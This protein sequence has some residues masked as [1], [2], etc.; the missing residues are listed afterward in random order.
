V[1]RP[2]VPV[3]DPVLAAVGAAC[4]GHGADL[5]PHP[6][7]L[8]RLVAPRTGALLRLHSG[9]LQSFAPRRQRTRRFRSR[10][11]SSSTFSTSSC[12]SCKSSAAGP[13][14]PAGRKLTA[15][16]SDRRHHRPRAGAAATMTRWSSPDAR[17]S[18]VEGCRR[19]CSAAR[20]AEGSAG[21]V[22]RRGA[23]CA[24]D[25]RAHEDAE[26]NRWD[27]GESRREVL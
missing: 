20:S 7:P 14:R 2:V 18:R 10:R 19:A 17:P 1:P 16:M 5:H 8:H 6:R 26:R 3:P 22:S 9:R 4:G 21:V 12:S 13:D 23:G 24:H 27:G 25:H 11:A 15:L